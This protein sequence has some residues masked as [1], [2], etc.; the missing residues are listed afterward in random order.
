MD[1]NSAQHQQARRAPARTGPKPY[2]GTPTFAVVDGERVETVGHEERVDT[3]WE[4][5]NSDERNGLWVTQRRQLNDALKA[6]RDD[7][8]LHQRLLTVQADMARITTVKGARLRGD[9]RDEDNSVGKTASD[10]KGSPGGVR[11][12][13]GDGALADD[14]EVTRR[15]AMIRRHVEALEQLVDQHRGIGSASDYALMGTE[16]KD[17]VILR[18]F[19]GWRPE[20]VSEFAPELGRPQTVKLVRLK[21][22]RRGV[23]GH[24][25]DACDCEGV[26]KAPRKDAA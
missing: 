11:P 25:P 10:G 6:E 9:E 23:C 16:E 26:R 1:R 2:Q 5:D 20:E 24:R 14:R 15:L 12:A 7:T 17:Q 21:A 3:E 4:A 8:P 18:D 22:E 13:H 19:E